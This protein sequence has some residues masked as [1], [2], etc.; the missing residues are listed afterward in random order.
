M[1]VCV[2]NFH[3]F[4]SFFTVIL[5]FQISAL[6]FYNYLNFVILLDLSLHH[7]MKRY[8]NF[9]KCFY[10]IR[11]IVPNS[12]TINS[13]NLFIV[14]VLCNISKSLLILY[15]NNIDK[16]ISLPLSFRCSLELVN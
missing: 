15:N 4:I 11:P 12:H 5:Q 8:T 6:E 14:F 3:C 9:D 13:K 16:Y 10:Y 7:F 1:Y 2:F